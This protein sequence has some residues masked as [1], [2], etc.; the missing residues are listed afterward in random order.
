M[1]DLGPSRPRHPPRESF[2]APDFFRK[3]SG[4]HLGVIFRLFSREVQR[5][6]R[7]FMFELR[8]RV[9]GSRFLILTF[10]IRLLGCTP[11]V[12][13]NRRTRSRALR[14]RDRILKFR[15]TR[16]GLFARRKDLPPD[17]R[18]Y[19]AVPV[20][21]CNSNA[22]QGGPVWKGPCKA[23]PRVTVLRLPP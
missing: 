8:I 2:A 5:I 12:A 9:S 15:A 21:H 19:V 1:A 6:L 11:R 13:R 17:G 16:G 3:S 20:F 23:L 18:F 4:A 14:T 7:F 22:S 10:L